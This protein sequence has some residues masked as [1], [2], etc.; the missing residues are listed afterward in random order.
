MLPRGANK[1]IKNDP[2]DLNMRTAGG[3]TL[4]KGPSARYVWP[5]R[6]RDS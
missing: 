6:L 1:A 3:Q 4:A 5:R 2:D